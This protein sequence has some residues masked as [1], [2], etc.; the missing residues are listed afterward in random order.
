[1]KGQAATQPGE[2]LRQLL[3]ALPGQ[4]LRALAGAHGVGHLLGQG[5][6]SKVEKK[7]AELLGNPDHLE[8]VL[9]SLRPHEKTAIETLAL[10]ACG[11]AEARVFSRALQTRLGKKSDVAAAMAALEK[12]GL[13]FRSR[14]G[15]YEHYF[16]PEETLYASLAAMAGELLAP[17][18]QPPLVFPGDG[19]EAPL[20]WEGHAILEDLVRLLGA[21]Y[22]NPA[23]VTREGRVY[24]NDFSRLLKCLGPA[25][26]TGQG[27]PPPPVPSQIFFDTITVP[28]PG[29]APAP[30]T[31]PAP[32]TVTRVA[33]PGAAAAGA[34]ACGI[35]PELRLQTLLAYAE[36]SRLAFV[37]QLPRRRFLQVNPD[38][39]G[40][41]QASGYQRWAGL[42]NY[43]LAQW[44]LQSPRLQFLL[45]FLA[46]VPPDAWLDLDGLAAHLE[47][48]SLP[49]GD[50]H[51]FWSGHET[52][53]EFIP[54]TALPGYLLAIGMVEQTVHEGR[55]G[56]RL[57]RA[58]RALLREET[59]PLP[60]AGQEFI[61]QP[62]YEVLVPPGLD[63]ALLWRLEELAVPLKVDR[64]SIYRLERPS[65]HRALEGGRKG[66]EI[67]SFL[68]H[69]ARGGLPQNVDFTLREWIQAYGRLYLMEA[70]LLRC[71]DEALAGTIKSLPGLKGF[72]LGELTPTDLL[73]DPA[74]VPALLLA[75]RNHGYTPRP[76]ITRPRG[77]KKYPW[78]EDPEE[79]PDWG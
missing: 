44:D 62:N 25:T 19:K 64:M 16:M 79:D 69:H 41:L 20:P 6:R 48:F 35:P 66:E 77:V 68:E 57:S 33:R 74:R 78:Q 13:V 9:Q 18:G 76:G 29:T 50:L 47:T 27:T 39:S 11:S 42:A 45:F 40:W 23:R 38:L 4:D 71:D 15:Y 58:G 32:G 54:L 43:C 7:L 22:R 75:L 51:G 5:S 37:R 24:S 49:G 55:M 2:G 12:L 70:T 21:L 17:P 53:Q 56:Y 52:Q 31:A 10:G 65:I 8:R 34:T 30:A 61:V 28:A 67:L 72:I 63:P 1:M 3:S 46:L 36:G 26:G 60:E 73:V 59:A 14:R